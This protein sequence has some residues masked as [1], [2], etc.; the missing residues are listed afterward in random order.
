MEKSF[1]ANICAGKLWWKGREVV[2]PTSVTVVTAERFGTD[3]TTQWG[4]ET[5]PHSSKAEAQ[6]REP[7]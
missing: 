4:N 6:C 3:K 2:F 7:L 5:Q 1:S